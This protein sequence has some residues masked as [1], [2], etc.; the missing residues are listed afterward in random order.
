MRNEKKNREKKFIKIHSLL[1]YWILLIVLCI[2]IKNDSKINYIEEKNHCS[3]LLSNDLRV[4][5]FQNQKI[6]CEEIV[7]YLKLQK[8]RNYSNK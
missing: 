1:L 3:F 8:K 2:H 7:L 5:E 6:R 4:I